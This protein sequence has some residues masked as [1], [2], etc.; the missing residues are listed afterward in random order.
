MT[1]ISC[2][3]FLLLLINSCSVNESAFSKTKYLYSDIEHLKIE[4]SEIFDI[5]QESYFVFIYSL[6]CYHCKQIEE[7][8][9]ETALK[10]NNLFYFLEYDDIIHIADDIDFTIGTS[11]FS[12]FAILGTPA[13]VK[14]EHK[15][16]ILNIAGSNEIAKIIEPHLF[17]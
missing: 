3:S 6:E 5:H 2:F 11:S 4:C 13:L 17:S 9:V 15:I 1:R 10:S 12:G 8:I 7:L 14:V 16:L